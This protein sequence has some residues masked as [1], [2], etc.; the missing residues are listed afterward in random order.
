MNL[1][2]VPPA[3]PMTGGA[4]NS[5]AGGALALVNPYTFNNGYY[6]AVTYPYGD[7]R[8][9]G[10]VVY[11]TQY[12]T[13]YTYTPNSYGMAVYNPMWGYAY[14]YDGPYLDYLFQKYG[15]YH[16]HHRHWFPFS[17]DQRC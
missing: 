10:A 11:S 3:I 1:A 6:P 17:L 16:Q 9:S 14:D 12:P 7:P 8:A 2:Y 13:P 4:S 15:R 5:Q